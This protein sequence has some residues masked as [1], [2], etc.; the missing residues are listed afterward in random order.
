M[1]VA[2]PQKHLIR[3]LWPD[4][5]LYATILLFLGAILGALFALATLSIPVRY[6][7][8]MPALLTEG[9]GTGFTLAASLAGGLFA[10]TCYRRRSPGSGFAAAG[11]VFLGFGALGLSSLLALAAAL[12]LLQARREGE[13]ANPATRTLHAHAWPDK[14]LAAA[15][16]L[17]VSA[18]ASL[19]WAAAL[20]AQSVDVRSLDAVAWGWL[21]LAGALVALAGAYL[22]YQQ[23]GYA[24]CLAATIASGCTGGFVVIGPVLSIG[25]LVLLAWSHR[26]REFA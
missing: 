7:P 24:G 20:L 21:S 12:F 26:E 10:W 9:W 5:H 22:A 17:V 2:H 16:L 8:D 4:K 19:V 15:L 3:D 13:H 6:A 11:L 25:S 23:Q 18:I 14:A 1:R